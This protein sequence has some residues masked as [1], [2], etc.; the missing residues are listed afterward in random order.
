MFSG[1]RHN[2]YSY[3]GRGRRYVGRKDG[4]KGRG[5][6]SG[7]VPTTGQGKHGC[8]YFGITVKSSRRFLAQAASS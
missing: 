8:H 1:F 5:P 7:D 3:P 2:N 4:Y 6:W